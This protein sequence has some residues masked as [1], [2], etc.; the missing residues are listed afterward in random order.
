MEIREAGSFLTATQWSCFR[1]CSSFF[2]KTVSAEYQDSS[3]F[4][5]LSRLV[6]MHMRRTF[7]T[8]R[9][10]CSLDHAKTRRTRRRGRLLTDGDSYFFFASSRLR[11]RLFLGGTTCL[12]C[13]PPRTST[14]AQTAI[15]ARCLPDRPWRLLCQTSLG[16]L[17]RCSHCSS[18]D[19]SAS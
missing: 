8:G 9:N 4:W 7:F 19:D 16:R 17:D 2:W 3:S 10:T 14:E 13:L 12:F 11:V 6:S 5:L 15:G 18:S 1:G